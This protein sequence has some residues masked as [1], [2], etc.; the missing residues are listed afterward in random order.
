MYF[1]GLF[2]D[3]VTFSICFL[4]PFYP[5]QFS[6]HFYLCFYVIERIFQGC[7]IYVEQQK[8][9]KTKTQI[10]KQT[11][12]KNVTKERRL[13]FLKCK[14]SDEKITKVTKKCKKSD[15]NDKNII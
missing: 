3:S 5:P 12:Q 13:N 7:K 1:S 10:Q 6:S 11:Y 4:Q 9:T 8:T 15:K 2:G 14:K